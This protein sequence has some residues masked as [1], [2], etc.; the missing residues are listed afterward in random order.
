MPTEIVGEEAKL[1]FQSLL[2][3]FLASTSLTRPQKASKL[4]SQVDVICMKED[5]VSLIFDHIDALSDA[6]IFSDT[7]WQDPD[8]LVPLLVK[9]TLKSG[10]P[11]SSFELISELRLLAI[12]TGKIKTKGFD[13]EDAQ[14]LLEE[15]LVHNLEF[16]FQEP[17]EETRATMSEYELQKVHNLFVFLMKNANL[18]GLKGKLADELVLICEQRPVVTRKAREIINI[19]RTSLDLDEEKESD[20]T[21]KRYIDAIY[22]PTIYSN[23][24]QDVGEYYKLLIGLS[25]ED[26]IMECHDMGKTMRST[27]LVSAYHAVLLRFLTEDAEEL[28]PLALQLNGTGKHQW[29]LHKKFLR[30]LIKNIVH[31]YNTQCIYGLSKIVEKGVLSRGAVKVALDNLMHIRLHPKAEEDIL[32]SLAYRHQELNALQYLIGATIRV[33]GQPLGIGQGNNPTCQS[34]R[35]I[36]MW[37]MHSPAKLINLIMTAATQNNLMFRFQGEEIESLKLGQGLVQNLDYNLDAVSVLLVP[38]LDKI[39]NE[40]M[41]RATGRGE[42]PHKWVNPALYGSW[43]QIG[44]ASV[45]NY[46]LNAIHDYKGFIRLFYAAHHLDYNG[47]HQLVYPNPVGIYITSAAGDMVG[48]HAISLLRVAK[49][50]NGEMRAY[51]L[52]PNNEGRQNW[53]QGIK[54]GVYGHGENR[55]ESS[56]PFYQFAS[57]VYAFHFNSLEVNMHLMEVPE[58]EIQEVYDLAKSSWGKNYIWNEMKKEW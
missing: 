16:V 6:G 38:K 30:R 48:F 21:L 41:K 7:P 1:N 55:G 3:E 42:D 50:E 9:G 23:K 13:K 58:K 40:M 37:S 8:K 26:L 20:R 36:S 49:D 32:K 47:N 46:L 45:Y 53:G 10:H 35:G 15:I 14:D 39:Y 18:E 22:A 31:P 27:G 57:R 24:A 17:T 28:V 19:V 52:N 29:K 34:A 43:I 5:G 2:D 4:L 12:A 11:N 51:F 44:F 54:P 33:I 56:L 25:E